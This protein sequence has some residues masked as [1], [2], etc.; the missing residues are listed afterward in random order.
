MQVVVIGAGVGGL[1][2]AHGMSE[3]AAD[4]RVFEATGPDRPQGAGLA[5]NPQGRRALTALGLADAMAPLVTGH[6]MRSGGLRLPSGR[7]L[8]RAPVVSVAGMRTVHRAQLRE[9]LL[10]ALPEGTV[11]FGTTARITDP[12]TGA[13]TLA[14]DG[15]QQAGETI[16]AD[17]VVAADG[18]WSLARA[19]LGVDPGVRSSGYGA[20]RGVTAAPIPGVRPCET[21]GRG[22]RFGMVPLPDERV[23]WFA[24]RR[25]STPSSPDHHGSVLGLFGHWHT[26]IRQ[27]VE[28]TDPDTVS[29]SPIDELAGPVPRFVSGRIALIGDAAHA[30]TPNLGQGANQALVDAAELVGQ[31]RRSPADPTGALARYQ[32]R[33]RGPTRR[34]ATASRWAGRIA[35][36]RSPARSVTA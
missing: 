14:Y 2:L 12:A 11:R 16:Q 1:A 7:W 28:A 19:A 27:V 22:L 30:M 5:L 31:L 8:L 32:A 34:I 17:L 26:P 9:A 18:I 20:W 3:I 36:L 24:E 10:S 35:H 33:R 6:P 4:V 15:G 23:Y 13:V 25:G 21:W 29:W